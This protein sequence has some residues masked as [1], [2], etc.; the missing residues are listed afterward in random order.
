M[1]HFYTHGFSRVMTPERGAKFCELIAESHSIEEAAE[2]IGVSIRTIQR[3]RKRDEDFDHEVRLALQ[4]TPDPLKLMEQGM[5]ACWQAA[6]S[7][8]GL[9]G[10]T[11][12]RRRGD[13]LTTPTTYLRTFVPTTLVCET[14]T[15][16][17]DQRIRSLMAYR[18]RRTNNPEK[19]F[20]N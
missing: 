16:H 9:A 18:L 20:R 8:L 3:E 11:P 10:L 2:A 4:K 5:D 17:Q 7:I 1:Q 12:A 19:H 6:P 15:L 13:Q 14:S